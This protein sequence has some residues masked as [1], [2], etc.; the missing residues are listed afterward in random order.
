[1]PNPIEFLFSVYLKGSPPFFARLKMEKVILSDRVKLHRFRK[2]DGTIVLFDVVKRDHRYKRIHHGDNVRA[3][4]FF[5][6]EQDFNSFLMAK[7]VSNLPHV[8]WPLTR[9]NGGP[10]MQMGGYEWRWVEDGTFLTAN[11]DASSFVFEYQEARALAH[12][13]FR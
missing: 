9:K 10:S 6:P 11:E 5:M 2:A 7:D 13:I 4:R 3:I 1:M 12:A 8:G